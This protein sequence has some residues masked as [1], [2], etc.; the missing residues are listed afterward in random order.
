ML[1]RERLPPFLD[2]IADFKARVYSLESNLRARGTE[3]RHGI[4]LKLG[5][6]WWKGEDQLN[7]DCCARQFNNRLV[8]TK[9]G[10]DEIAKSKLV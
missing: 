8:A 2:L 10:S 4:R 6:E 9:R 3:V 1:G 7:H 5:T